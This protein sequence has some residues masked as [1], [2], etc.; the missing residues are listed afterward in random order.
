LGFDSSEA[1][2][3]L[4]RLAYAILHFKPNEKLYGYHHDRQMEEDDQN[5]F[6]VSFLE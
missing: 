6:S 4:S 1:S 3:R 5:P 2:E